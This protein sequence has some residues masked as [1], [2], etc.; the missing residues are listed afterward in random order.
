MGG[1]AVVA[2]NAQSGCGL[3]LDG[4]IDEDGRIWHFVGDIAVAAGSG[5]GIIPQ[6]SFLINI[7]YTVLL[8]LKL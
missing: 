5:S 4:R 1:G 6:K 3:W 7:I 2:A 8:Y